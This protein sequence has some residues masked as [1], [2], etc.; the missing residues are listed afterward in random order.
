VR[1]IYRNKGFSSPLLDEI[2]AHITADPER[3]NDV[4]MREELGLHHE[5]LEIPHRSALRVGISYLIGA[6]VPIVPYTIF[7]PSAAI[8]VSAGLTIT[9]LFTVGALKTIFTARSWWRSGL[10]SLGV[11]VAAA[12]VTYGAGSMFG[13]H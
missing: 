8:I 11:G 5:H 2:V 3:W 9:A 6:A 4:M 13:T 10:E 1:A 12:A 7:A